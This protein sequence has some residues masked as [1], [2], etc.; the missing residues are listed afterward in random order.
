MRGFNNL[1]KPDK[2]EKVF[3]AK[4][5]NSSVMSVNDGRVHIV[6]AIKTRTGYLPPMH[7][8]K[9]VNQDYG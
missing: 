9:K 8:K 2:I 5:P 6:H 7:G 1:N 4:S 3:K